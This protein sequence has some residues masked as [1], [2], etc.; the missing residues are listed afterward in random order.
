MHG[1]R[2]RN[3]PT[4][5]DL[6][7]NDAPYVPPCVYVRLF[8]L[9][10]EGAVRNSTNV[11]ARVRSVC[12]RVSPLSLSLPPFPSLSQSLRQSYAYTRTYVQPARARKLERY[13]IPEKSTRTDERPVTTPSSRERTQRSGSVHFTEVGPAQPTFQ[14]IERS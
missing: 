14:M 12:T 10:D 9:R 8:V 3:A 13:V 4:F 2:R 1:L 6:E 5:A 7:R 11:R